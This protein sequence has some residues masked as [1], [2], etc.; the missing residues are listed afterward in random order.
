MMQYRVNPT[1]QHGAVKGMAANDIFIKAFS[2]R[3]DKAILCTKEM[4]YLR[5]CWILNQPVNENIRKEFEE[6]DKKHFKEMGLDKLPPSIEASNSDFVEEEKPLIFECSK[7]I[8]NGYAKSRIGTIERLNFDTDFS[9]QDQQNIYEALS[10]IKTSFPG[11]TEVA[12]MDG[13]CSNHFTFKEEKEL[14]STYTDLISTIS[15]IEN[16]GRFSTYSGQLIHEKNEFL[17][18]SLQY[19]Y[20][21]DGDLFKHLMRDMQSTAFNYSL[22]DTIMGDRLV[23]VYDIYTRRGRIVLHIFTERKIENEEKSEETSGDTEKKEDQ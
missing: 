23:T 16:N 1:D 10:K 11:V 4:W 6:L 20:D 13:D 7:L 12:I 2:E 14:I 18:E 3:D 22:S 19:L 5:K 8:Q 15:E 17:N 9:E 21:N